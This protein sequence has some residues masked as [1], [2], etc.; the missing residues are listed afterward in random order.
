[1][2]TATPSDD[3]RYTFD[4]AAVEALR[5]EKPWMSN[6]RHISK[7]FISPSAAMKMLKHTYTGC[8]RGVREGGKPQ[9]V[10][11][12]LLGR[13]DPDDPRS[14]IV[15]D[16]FALPIV[17]FETRV[18]ADDDQA[19]NYMIELS[20]NLEKTRNERIMGWYHSHPFDVDEA[21]NHCYMSTTD[22]STQL[23]WQRAEDPNGNPW[24]AI[25]IDPLR[26]LAKSTP[27]F[28]AFRVYPPEYNAPANEC[29]DGKIVTSDA[30]RVEHWGAA[31]N[32]CV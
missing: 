25:V 26:S 31:W 28:G 11:G 12:M 32:R 20:E 17:G 21:H 4:E 9:E 1:M 19:I 2:A 10:M 15:T 7:V 8:E 16:V 29:P 6:P 14:L 23:A 27:E 5:A 3:K 18:V 13:P 24:L 30:V 22:I